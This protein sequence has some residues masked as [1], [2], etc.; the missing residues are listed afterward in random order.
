[1][2]F[3]IKEVAGK[4]IGSALLVGGGVNILFY[5]FNTATGDV[6]KALAHLLPGWTG[7]SG[8][9]SSLNIMPLVFPA[10]LCIIGLTMLLVKYP[11]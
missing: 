8:I 11:E 5:M 9:G 7:S 1:M 6:T 4:L 3:S 2:S 10:I